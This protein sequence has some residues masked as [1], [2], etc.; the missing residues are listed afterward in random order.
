MGYELFNPVFNLERDIKKTWWM[1]EQIRTNEVYAQNLYA[2]C[3]NNHFGP[4]DVWAILKTITWECSWSYAANMV[5]EIREDMF[6]RWYCSGVQLINPD[7]VPESVIVP[8]I[9]RDL[10][11]LGWIV[12]D[13]NT[14]NTL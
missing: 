3:C 8:A 12:V 7:F 4:Y 2:A 6:D 13:C 5:A 11:T 10:E 1:V 9:E 14:K